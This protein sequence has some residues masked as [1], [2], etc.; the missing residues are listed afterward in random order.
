METYHERKNS[1]SYKERKSRAGRASPEFWGT[2]HLEF[3]ARRWQ[4]RN[5]LWISAKQLRWHVVVITVGPGL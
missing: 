4:L 1:I 5:S 2:R 3:R